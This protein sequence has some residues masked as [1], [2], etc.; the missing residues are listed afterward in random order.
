M[1]LAQPAPLTYEDFASFPDD[2]I[3]RELIDGEVVVTPAPRIRHQDVVG[4]L[5]LSFGA[6]V[7]SRGGGRVFVAPCDVVFA[8]H[9][10]VEPDIVFVADDQKAIIGEL[11]IQG[12]PRFLAEVLSDPR[13]DRVRKRD[14]YGRFGVGE[15]WVVDPD[16]D[17]VEV[18]TLTPGADAY[19]KP[20]IVEPGEVLLPAC[21]PGLQVDVAWLFRP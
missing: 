14:L 12:A 2:H 15:Y 4:R 13:T 16:S 19:P 11:N 6:H 1:A 10:V 17:R 7:E 18:Y 8:P 5:F 21:L 20:T 3:R 9:Q